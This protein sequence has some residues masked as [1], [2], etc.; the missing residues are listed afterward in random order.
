MPYSESDLGFTLEDQA[1]FL[2]ISYDLHELAQEVLD[3]PPVYD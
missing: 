3:A 2:I 1:A